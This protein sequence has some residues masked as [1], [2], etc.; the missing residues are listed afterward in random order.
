M[1]MKMEVNKRVGQIAA[2]ASK[3]MEVV[4][5]ALT[6]QA[7]NRRAMLILACRKRGHDGGGRPGNWTH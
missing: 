4:R 5:P 7:Q 1:S 2:S 6:L 3:T